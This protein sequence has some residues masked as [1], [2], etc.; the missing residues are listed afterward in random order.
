MQERD[1]IRKAEILSITGAAILGAGLA[2]IAEQWL[3]PVA[4][5]LLI[6]GVLAHGL[7]MFQRRRL[8]KH[9]GVARSAWEGPAYWLCW[10]V[11]GGILLYAF[12]GR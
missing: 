5:P 10:I 6:L 7:G 9:A 11:L 4:I 8:E 1:S 12:L 2:L 3:S